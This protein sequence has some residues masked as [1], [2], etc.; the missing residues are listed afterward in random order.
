MELLLF[1]RLV[2]KFPKFYFRRFI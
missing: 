1:L 2:H